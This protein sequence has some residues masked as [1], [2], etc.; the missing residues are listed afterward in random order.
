MI[1]KQ[2]QQ[3]LTVEVKF[4]IQY[5]YGYIIDNLMVSNYLIFLTSYFLIVLSVVGHG[6]LAIKFTK[7]NV[8]LDEIGF[9]GL[10]GIFFLILYS[11]VT[12]FFINHGYL[13]NII[14]MIIGVVSFIFFRS[15]FD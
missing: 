2:K 11:Y 8:P 9:V 13:H 7:T 3:K 15:K 12:H 4:F 1:K 6:A 10:A 5:I 14:F